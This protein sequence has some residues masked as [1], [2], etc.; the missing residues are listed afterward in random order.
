MADVR[1]YAAQL[2]VM[3]TT[4]IQRAKA[5]GGGTWRKWEEGES[6]PTLLTADRVRRYM[7]ENPPAAMD[8]ERSVA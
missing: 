5:G 6:S 3:P 1:A 4:I 2:G 8:G 7:A